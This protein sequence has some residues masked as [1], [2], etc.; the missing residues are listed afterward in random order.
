M[1][2]IKFAPKRSPGSKLGGI[3]SGRLLLPGPFS[4]IVSCSILPVLLFEPVADTSC[5]TD[6][7]FLWH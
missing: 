3:M 5:Q 6:W 1:L 2:A 4:L 7:I